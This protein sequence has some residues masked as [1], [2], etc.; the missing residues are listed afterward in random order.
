V[1]ISGRCICLPCSSLRDRIG[2]DKMVGGRGRGGERQSVLSWLRSPLWL[3][4]PLPCNPSL[5]PYHI[6]SGMLPDNRTVLVL[7]LVLPLGLRRSWQEDKSAPCTSQHYQQNP[8][9]K[10]LNTC[11]K[12]KKKEGGG[13][14][15]STAWG[16]REEGW[17]IGVKQSVQETL[18]SKML[19]SVT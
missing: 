11:G 18:G 14:K 3:L 10:Y 7:R 19:P 12:K 5:A 16:E 13:R 9:G 6:L 8:G 4:Y 2:Q 15:N 1:W 17:L